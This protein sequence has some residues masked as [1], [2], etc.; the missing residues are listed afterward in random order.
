[1]ATQLAVDKECLLKMEA[2]FEGCQPA[3]QGLGKARIPP[4][5]GILISC[6][7]L[8]HSI[9]IKREGDTEA[10]R[11]HSQYERKGC[12]KHHPQ[13]GRLRDHRYRAAS[14]AALF[15]ATAASS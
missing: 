8:L 7:K 9:V 10:S 1:M 12:D 11:D 3:S 15:D 5:S 2:G 14:A 6:E 4:G 13:A